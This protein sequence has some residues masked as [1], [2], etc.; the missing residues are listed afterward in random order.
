MVATGWLAFM[1]RYACPVSFS[2]VKR[3]YVLFSGEDC[4]VALQPLISPVHSAPFGW[5][6]LLRGVTPSEDSFHCDSS[7]WLFAWIS[8][9]LL[10]E[11]RYGL[12]V[13]ISRDASWELGLGVSANSLA[14][15]G[16]VGGG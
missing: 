3:S 14:C 4:L 9:C 8:I 12:N 2:T 11:S 16:M 15:L 13:P 10:R 1:N 5:P 7:Q 6:Q